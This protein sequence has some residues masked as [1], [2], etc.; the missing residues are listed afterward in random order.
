M[1]VERLFSSDSSIES[2]GSI[3]IVDPAMTAYC[4]LTGGNAGTVSDDATYSKGYAN[5]FIKYIYN[6]YRPLKKKGLYSHMAKLNFSDFHRKIEIE[7]PKAGETAWRTVDGE[8]RPTAGDAHMDG[9]H[10][11]ARKDD[12]RGELTSNSVFYNDSGRCDD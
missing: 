10:R 3:E 1:A 12:G 8:P 5:D 11:S 4:S 9:G 7:G 2:A 6:T